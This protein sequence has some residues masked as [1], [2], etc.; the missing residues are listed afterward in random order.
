MSLLSGKILVVAG[1]SKSLVDNF[2]IDWII[3]SLNLSSI[4][5]WNSMNVEPL[6]QPQVFSRDTN[7]SPV[8]CAVELF[9]NKTSPIAVLQV[10]SNVVNRRNFTSEVISFAK[11]ESMN[12]IVVV[13]SADG[14]MLS[15]DE[16][17]SRKDRIITIYSNSVKED[18]HS[19]GLVRS[20]IGQSTEIPVEAIITFVSGLGYMEIRKRSESLARAVLDYFHLESPLAVP[21]SVQQLETDPPVS[22]EVGRIL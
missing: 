7:A 4:S 10:R 12:R 1:C 5:V 3:Q 16:L 8:T 19:A 17:E 11:S 14:C 18:I 2:A 20:L 21:L 15:G 22:V 6:I 13:G 9:T